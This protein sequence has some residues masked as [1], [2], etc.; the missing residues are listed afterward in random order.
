MIT[1]SMYEVFWE[2][3]SKAMW[4]YAQSEQYHTIVEARDS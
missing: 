1:I 2:N 3:E 4:A